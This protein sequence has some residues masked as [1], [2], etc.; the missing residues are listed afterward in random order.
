[1]L[2]SIRCNLGFMDIGALEI[3][4]DV[5]DLKLKENL[6]IEAALKKISRE[7]SKGMKKGWQRKECFQRR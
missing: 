3:A 6:S 7:Y 2:I 4:K 5:Q 1:M